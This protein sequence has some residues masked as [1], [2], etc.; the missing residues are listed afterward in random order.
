M[1]RP[2]PRSTPFPYTTLFRSRSGNHLPGGG[3]SELRFRSAGAGEQLRRVRCPRRQRIRQLHR[4]ADRDA[5]QRCAQRDRKS[6]RLNSSHLV[7]SYA[8]FCL[9]KTEVYVV[10]D[11]PGDGLFPTTTWTPGMCLV[12][13]YDLKRPTPD[14][15]PYSLSLTL[16]ASD[17]DDEQTAE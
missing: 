10:L 2:P 17:C 3:N 11:Y 9:K 7:I 14:P 15:G 6:T 12:D 5:R 1:I 16:L 13:R 8:V 4:H